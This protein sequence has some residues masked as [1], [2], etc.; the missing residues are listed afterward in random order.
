MTGRITLVA[1]QPP[2]RPTGPMGP[3]PGAAPVSGAVPGPH[4][5][6]SGVP[7]PASP[8]IEKQPNR[9]LRLW[10]AMMAGIVALLCLGGVGVFVSLYDSATEI[11][12]TAPDAVVDS[13]LRSYLVDRDDTE[14]ALY[15][16][17]SGLDL[18]AVAALRTELVNR[19]KEFDVKVNVSWSSLMVSGGVEDKRSVATDLII[20]GTKNGDTLSR[21]TESWAFGV[22]DE[23]GWRVCST[24]KVS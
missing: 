5:P 4:V 10:L 6:V 15:T 16:C 17:K 14:A 3:Q 22:V 18:A 19:E 11:K 23:D 20:S 1:V 24:S 21:R 2:E 12:R 13:F 8:V 7:V 9:R